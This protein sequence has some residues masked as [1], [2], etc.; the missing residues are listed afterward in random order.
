[1]PKKYLVHVYLNIKSP[2]TLNWFSG[3][4]LP[5][6]LVAEYFPLMLLDLKF[7]QRQKFSLDMTYMPET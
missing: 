7:E 6:N 3:F 4:H 5:L 2:F 1:M